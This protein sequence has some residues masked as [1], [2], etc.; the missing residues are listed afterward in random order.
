MLDTNLIA[1]ERNVS[2]YDTPTPSQLLTTN[3]ADRFEVAV[4]FLLQ[5]VAYL[6]ERHASKV[7][8]QVRKA[9]AA[10]KGSAVPS[11]MPTV[12][13]PL[14]RPSP[15]VSISRDAPAG[16]IDGGYPAI[17]WNPQDRPNIS[18]N[19]SGSTI[20]KEPGTAS[21]RRRLPSQPAAPQTAPFSPVLE[22]H[23]SQSVSSTTSDALSGDSEEDDASLPAQS[24]IIRR[25]PRF[26]QTESEQQ[27][28]YGDDE[29]SEPA[30]QPFKSTG[31]HNAV[32]DLASTLKDEGQVGARRG[33]KYT[34]NYS[35]ISDSSGGSGVIG[36]AGKRQSEQS[37][38]SALSPRRKAELAGRSSSA[39]SKGQSQEGSDGT[40]SMGSSFSDLDGKIWYFL[41][42]YYSVI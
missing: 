17:P 42:D 34:G 6:T 22:K 26:Q 12:D 20:Q 15:A 7:R 14:N 41:V 28:G 24:R 25:P 39:R 9:T 2:R 8:A 35:Q 23:V 36:T 38:A 30:F 4:E 18:R 19:T 27:Y 33:I 16:Q 5:Q 3:R 13:A 31:D 40:P 10:A 11:P 32:H 37:P 1:R 29:E 21:P